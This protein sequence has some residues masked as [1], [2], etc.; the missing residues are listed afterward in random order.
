MKLEFPTSRK[1][2]TRH[3][4]ASNHGREKLP[5]KP[6]MKSSHGT[7]WNCLKLFYAERAGLDEPFKSPDRHLIK[8][9]LNVTKSLRSIVSEMRAPSA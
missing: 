1:G 2:R 4:F 7:D 9:S 3:E 8:P 5:C 6:V